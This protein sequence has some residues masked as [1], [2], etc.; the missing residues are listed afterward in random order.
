MF[1]VNLLGMG[2]Q[3]YLA[4]ALLV[5]IVNGS[6]IKNGFVIKEGNACTEG[7]IIRHFMGVKVT[8]RS[9]VIV[10]SYTSCYF[11]SR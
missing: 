7:T 10:N 3:L 8:I 9:A 6:V 1:P 11:N 4:W 5:S 2:G